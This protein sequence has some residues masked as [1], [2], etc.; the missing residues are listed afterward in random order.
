M[1]VVVVEVKGHRV[2]IRDG[3]WIGQEG[4]PL[5]PQPL[6]QAKNNSMALQRLIRREI[7]G[8]EFP[9]YRRRSHT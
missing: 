9:S 2:G 5:K 3:I 1:G 4:T 8:L 6:D 7:P